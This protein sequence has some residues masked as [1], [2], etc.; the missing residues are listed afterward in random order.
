[1]KGSGLN[2]FC[3]AKNRGK[4]QAGLNQRG[5]SRKPRKMEQWKLDRNGS[6]SQFSIVYCSMAPKFLLGKNFSGGGI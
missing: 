3:D 1:M 6:N 5:W 2:N 4:R